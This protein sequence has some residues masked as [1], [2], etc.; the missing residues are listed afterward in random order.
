[1]EMPK[2]AIVLLRDAPY[3]LQISVMSHES[4]VGQLLV[5]TPQPKGSLEL[6]VSEADAAI[7]AFESV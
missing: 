7:Q 6:F 4:Q 2:N 1:M 3:P 5:V